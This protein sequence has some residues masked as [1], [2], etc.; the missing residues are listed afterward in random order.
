MELAEQ[1]WVVEPSFIT[2]Q[3]SYAIY[4]KGHETV[5]GTF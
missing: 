1:V 3:H 5:Q 4:R 2:N